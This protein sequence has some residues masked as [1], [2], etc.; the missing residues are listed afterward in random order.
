MTAVLA[1]ALLAVGT[2]TLRVLFATVLRP[3][4][5][6]AKVRTGLAYVGPAVLAGLVVTLLAGGQGTAGLRLP[7]PQLAA[8]VVAGTVA[9]RGAKLLPTIAA[10]FVVLWT[11][12]IISRM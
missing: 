12:E 8:L 3:A 11:S 9:L 1:L 7:L 5:L 6:P 10:A 2:W 4:A